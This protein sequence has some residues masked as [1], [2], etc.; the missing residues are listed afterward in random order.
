M[1]DLENMTTR[2]LCRQ[3]RRH[4]GNVDGEIAE[5]ARRLE[6]YGPVRIDPD[7]EGTWP[8]EEDAGGLNVK[9][10][11][12]WDAR[13]KTWGAFPYHETWNLYHRD[14]ARFTHWRRINNNPPE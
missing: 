13:R 12:V 5:A 4:A 7:D 11:E 3:L 14:P 8:T 1:T 2:E 6:R 9:W 10:V